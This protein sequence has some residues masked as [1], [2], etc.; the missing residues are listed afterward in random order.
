VGLSDINRVGAQVISGLT[1]TFR[2][3]GQI[4][5]TIRKLST[6]LIF[7]PRMHWLVPSLAPFTKSGA[8]TTTLSTVPVLFQELTGEGAGL[9]NCSLKN[10]L[11]ATA[12]VVVRG[13]LTMHEVESEL[14]EVKK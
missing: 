12:S 13:D 1:S 6:N 14:Q 8:V 11:A 7:F 2:F 3:P 10:Q 5:S 4:N 9:I